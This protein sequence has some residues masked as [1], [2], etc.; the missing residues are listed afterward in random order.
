MDFFAR[1]IQRVVPKSYDQCW[2]EV[3]VTKQF[4]SNFGG[5]NPRF[6]AS[7]EQVAGDRVGQ[8]SSN[9]RW[10]YG[11]VALITPF[12]FPIEIPVLQMMGALMMG[13]HLTFKGDQRTSIVTE[14]FLRL[15]LD[16]GL[17]ADDISLLNSDGPTMSELMRQADFR[18]TQFTGSSTV[19][20]QLCE[21]TRGKVKI[22]DAGFDFKILGPDVG[23][24]DYVAWQSDADAYAASGQKCSAQSILFAHQNWVDE[25]FFDR[26][27]KLAA[28]RNLAELTVG[29]VLTQTTEQMLEH[30]EAL[31]SLPGAYVAFGGKELEG[32]TAPPQY[33][34]IE[35][36]AVYVPLD[37][38]LASEENFALATKEVFGP[39]QVITSFD[40]ASEELVLE[41]CERMTN[42][43]TAAVVSNDPR[44]QERVLGSTVNGTTYCGR[45]AR[46]TG[47]SPKP[48][49]W[50]LW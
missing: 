48:L 42:H 3:L 17:P 23:D 16:C 43:L 32:N 35:P 19:A 20:E 26:I 30:A 9:W 8:R 28:R 45:K 15:L 47:S 5:D 38:I 24:V 36:T 27:A 2:Y 22:E 44:F 31:A 29:P 34:C 4:L 37:Q 1:L 21:M 14:Q 46:T 11:S 33:G 12:N 18:T 41:A 50:A 10:P 13:N 39:F 7:G 49:V 40:D 25:G 6:T